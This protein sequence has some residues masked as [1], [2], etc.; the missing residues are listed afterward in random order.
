MKKFSFPIRL[1]VLLTVMAMLMLVVG[2]ITATMANL[3]HQ[4]KT[5][6]VRDYSAGITEDITTGIQT[7]LGGYVSATRVLSEVLFADYV[8][9]SS[10]HKLIRPLFAA[11]PELLALVSTSID[12]QPV[13]LYNATALK[14]ES[15]ESDAVLKFAPYGSQQVESTIRMRS[16][17]V[18]SGQ[19]VVTLTM[20]YLVS[21]EEEARAV[22]AVISPALFKQVLQRA[23]AFDA[24]LLDANQEALVTIGRSDADVQWAREAL[25][26]FPELGRSSVVEYDT[27]NGKYIAG[28][29]KIGAAE[30]TIVTRIAASAAYLTARQLLDNLVKVGLAIIFLASLGGVLVSRRLTRPLER[31]SEAVRKVAKGNFDVNVDIQ[32]KDEIGQL[33]KSFNEMAAELNVREQSLRKAQL[34]LV[35]SEKMAA[36]GTLSAGLAHEVKNP[37]SAVLGYAQLAKRKLSQPEVVREHLDII[38][39]ETRRCN[40]IIGNLMQFSRQGK[41]EFNEISIN[42]V[43][44]KSVGIVDHQ[45]S[46]HKVHVTTDLAND[47]P[48]LL[49]NANQIQQVLMNLAINAQ[50]AMGEDGGTISIKTEIDEATASALI[51]VDDTGPGIPE[52]VA[53]NIF[54]PFFTTKAAGQGTGLGLSVSYGIIQEHKGAIHVMEAPGG[55]ARFE[56]RLPLNAARDTGA[57]DKIAMESA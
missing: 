20:G 3:F 46:L 39:S 54:E 41:G 23:G 52:D 14:K 9:P 33:S 35:Q 11:Y 22:V 49:G 32:S 24:V 5:T 18:D 6:Y 4:D 56:I 48:P 45:L 16:A 19:Q 42:A 51:T 13:T 34:A 57:M 15:I 31:L 40:D 7:I 53:A 30:I 43:I 2:V 26:H 38:E 47:I 25:K 36:V 55:G 10:K 8:E 12:G 28:A 37:L 50:H 44:E 17:T 21:G 29:S 27:G 1:K